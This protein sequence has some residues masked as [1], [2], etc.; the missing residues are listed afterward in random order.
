MVDA[1]CRA[2]RWAQPPLGCVIDLRPADVAA[3][4]EIGL[5]DGSTVGVGGLVVDAERHAR[6]AAADAALDTVLARRVLTLED[7]ERFWFLRYASTIDELR[8]YIASK[9][10][11]TRLDAG[12]HA[13][14]LEVQRT[15]P[16]GRLCLRE[17]VVIRRLRPAI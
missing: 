12:T 8:D 9:W 14:A 11:H 15:H 17:R 1:L 16:D 5:A 2:R 6:H 3:H 7:E 10:Q 13:R 4:V